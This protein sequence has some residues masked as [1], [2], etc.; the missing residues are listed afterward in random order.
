M[1]VREGHD[2]N[3]RVLDIIGDVADRD[4]IIVDDFSISG[5]TLTSVAEALEAS[6][7]RRIFACL[8]HVL[9]NEAAVERIEATQL[10]C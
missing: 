5:R 4:A 2:E 7:A 1:K 10:K 9:L 6:G 8:S 3:A